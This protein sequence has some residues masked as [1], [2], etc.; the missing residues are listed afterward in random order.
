MLMSGF[1]AFLA[2]LGFGV[3]FNVKGRHLL[4]AALCGGIG[5]FAYALALTFNISETISLMIGIGGAAD[6]ESGDNFS[7]LCLDSAC[8]RRRY[9]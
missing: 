2:S 3:I 4:V 6:E 9:V 8:S 7:G 1:S 5:G